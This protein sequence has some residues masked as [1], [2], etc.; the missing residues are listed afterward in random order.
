MANDLTLERQDDILARIFTAFYSKNLPLLKAI[1]QSGRSKS[2]FYTIPEDVRNSAAEKV[3]EELEAARTEEE[4]ALEASR[5]QAL[6]DVRREGIDAW[7]EAVKVLREPAT[8]KSVGAFVREKAAVDL[9]DRV[10]RNFK[11]DTIRAAVALDEAPVVQ[12]P[13]PS[14]V[15]VPI[16][17]MPNTLDP[18]RQLSVPAPDGSWQVVK[19]S[20]IVEGETVST[21]SSSSK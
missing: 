5:L 19:T 10:A 8:D 2:W 15:V 16:L 6:I 20:E 18:V 3:R 13:A 1:E 17:P 11:D 21:S 7:L 14:V 4:E 12:L 9:I